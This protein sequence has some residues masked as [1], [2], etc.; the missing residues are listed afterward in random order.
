MTYP[1]YV[2]SGNGGGGPGVS[3]PVFAFINHTHPL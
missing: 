3:P 1:P 2:S